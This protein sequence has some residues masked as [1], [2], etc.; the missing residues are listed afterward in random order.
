MLQNCHWN[1]DTL[2]NNTNGI[3]SD[4]EIIG[5][6]YYLQKSLFRG[7]MRPILTKLSP[8]WCSW[9]W[10]QKRHISWLWK[11]WSKSHFTK[12]NIS[13]I[14]KPIWSKF[15]SIMMT[16]LR[17][18]SHLCAQALTS[19]SKT[20]DPLHGCTSQTSRLFVVHRSSFCLLSFC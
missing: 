12:N 13:A 3:S 5:Q 8:K 20:T 16:P 6:G 4:L 7:N 15:S 17:E 9:G 14:M 10:Q 18:L 11:C 19:L 1:D 2:T